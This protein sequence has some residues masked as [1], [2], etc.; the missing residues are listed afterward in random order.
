LF[1]R[2]AGLTEKA[3]VI[4]KYGSLSGQFV[5]VQALPAGYGIDYTYNDG[6]SSNNIAL[7]RLP[8]VFTFNGNINQDFL[9]PANWTGS[10]GRAATPAT[11]G[12]LDTYLVAANATLDGDS[13]LTGRCT[14]NGGVTLTI[15]NNGTMTLDGDYHLASSGLISVFGTFTMNSS[16]SR[17]N[18]SIFRGGDLRVETTG[19]FTRQGPG[20]SEMSVRTVNHGSFIDAPDVR[21]SRA[22]WKD[23][24]FTNSANGT[25][26]LRANVDR[27]EA[28]VSI[29]NA[30]TMII[31]KNLGGRAETFPSLSNSG[32]LTLKNG[33]I[34]SSGAFV[35]N[36]GVLHGQG[37]FYNFTN[38]GTFNLTGPTRFFPLNSGQ[39][40][41]Q[42]GG[43][44]NQGTHKVTF[45]K[46][47]NEGTW[48]GSG[49][50]ELN[51][52][53]GPSAVLTIGGSGVLTNN[54]SWNLSEGPFE[55]NIAGTLGGTAPLTIPANGTLSLA[56]G[57]IAGTV[58]A[59]GTTTNADST[60]SG[61]LTLSSD[62][63]LPAG[64][65][66][67]VTSSGS[68]TLSNANL[69]G[70]DGSLSVNGLLITNGNCTVEPNC[71]VDH[72]NET[73]L[74]VPAGS[75]LTTTK[76]WQVDNA[77]VQIDGLW[78]Y[79][80]IGSTLQIPSGNGGPDTS[81]L[82]GGGT[83]TAS[84]IEING[85]F[86]PG[87]ASGP[88]TFHFF[89]NTVL[90][91]NSTTFIDVSSSAVFDRFNSTG[92]LVLNGGLTVNF[93]TKPLADPGSYNF[94]TAGGSL[95]G[96]F[97]STFADG[98][99]ALRSM[100]YDSAEPGSFTVSLTHVY[101]A[102]AFFS[103]L[104]EGVNA[105]PTDDPNNDGITNLQ[106][107]ALATNPLGA[108]GNEGKKRVSID[109]IEGSNYFTITLPVRRGAA[110]NNLPNFPNSSN[111]TTT[112]D[113]VTYEIQGT[114]DLSS[115]NVE[116]AE[117][118]PA[119]S[120]GLPVL[121]DLD[122]DGN[123]DWEYHTFRF[124]NPAAPLDDSFMRIKITPRRSLSP[125][126]TQPLE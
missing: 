25:A 82:R 69:L 63:A 50:I 7:V 103:G 43:I 81:A 119:L 22:I 14:I 93:T 117:V 58:I 30:G 49:E 100:D 107:F 53:F 6:T 34:D 28:S 46:F 31:H 84:N 13:V 32:T 89:G 56:G 2:G 97:Q 55:F 44:I 83:L 54:G 24:Y 68:L 27:V 65:T 16:G 125:G 66:F 5:E 47:L 10:F 8:E 45:W 29:E 115:W 18:P 72:A 61:A 11:M 98:L 37:P 78:N 91:P 42:A 121:A 9:N 23:L 26:E 114:L 57:E 59:S 105:A 4:A 85:R 38:R 122:G 1:G 41:N 76:P 109:T 75:A 106:H 73:A 111:P 40:T 77:I 120:A 3:Y 101:K 99:N 48:T 12:P 51:V 71:N 67:T 74:L 90:G 64:N 102:W 86:Q 62:L 116:L 92:N 104:T 118:T 112:I 70:S 124:T 35:S 113:D 94:A 80:A 52:T 123:P 39:P 88:A 87:S 15:Q 79:N 60:I 108:G 21:S 110:F 20:Y 17:S 95:S 36:S 33:F 96:S 19:S 126:P